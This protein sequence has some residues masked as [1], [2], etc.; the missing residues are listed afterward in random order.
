MHFQGADFGHGGDQLHRYIAATVALGRGQG[1]G[2]R[3]QADEI[4]AGQLDQIAG[5]PGAVAHR[6]RQVKAH[7]L[8]QA[9]REVAPRQS[10][11]VARFGAA[12]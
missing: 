11:F 7:R 10:D 3:R 5:L 12:G 2:Q 6:G 1:G 8:A 9:Q 4:L